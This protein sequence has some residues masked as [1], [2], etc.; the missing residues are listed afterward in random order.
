[1]KAGA[2]TEWSSSDIDGWFVGQRNVLSDNTCY[3]LYAT[4]R[5]DPALAP[6]L[7]IWI[8]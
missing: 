2:P 3:G 7:D 1:M 6:R 4:I 8:R 5:T